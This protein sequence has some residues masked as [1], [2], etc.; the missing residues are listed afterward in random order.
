MCVTTDVDSSCPSAC[1]TPVFRVTRRIEF[2]ETDMAGIVHFASFFHYMEEVEHA[3]LRS[4]GTSVY[5]PEEGGHL[6]WPRVK[7][8]CEYR[9]PVRFEDELDI[10]LYLERLGRT[11]LEYRHVMSHGGRLVAEGRITAVYCRF[12]PGVKPEPLPLPEVIRRL[13]DE[14][15][16][17]VPPA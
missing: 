16:A 7:S 12:R 15:A 13:G 3:F 11:S 8:A 14:V 1:M 2:N 9:M 10:E 17:Q 5:V 6:S 4:L